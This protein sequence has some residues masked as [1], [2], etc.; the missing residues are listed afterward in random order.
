MA[1]VLE[2]IAQS[3]K[4]HAYKEDMWAEQEKLGKRVSSTGL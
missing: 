4:G 2:A 1:R 3:W